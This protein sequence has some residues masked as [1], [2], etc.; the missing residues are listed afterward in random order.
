MGYIYRTKNC[1]NHF[2]IV[3]QIIFIKN[4][5]IK[6]KKMMWQLIWRNV[7]VAALNATL[8]LLVIL[9]LNPHNTRGH[10]LLEDNE[11]H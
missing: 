11:I 6:I 9:A 7:R 5:K 3:G 8:Q 2:K 1:K 4:K 10:F